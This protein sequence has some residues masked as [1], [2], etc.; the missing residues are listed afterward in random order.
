MLSV[1][2]SPVNH[3]GIDQKDA[4]YGVLPGSEVALCGQTHDD[5]TRYIY[6]I[7]QYIHIYITNLDLG[8]LYLNLLKDFTNF[9]LHCI[10]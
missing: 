3:I 1:L 9:K 8:N 5:D 4:S 7:D 10:R 2:K 6:V